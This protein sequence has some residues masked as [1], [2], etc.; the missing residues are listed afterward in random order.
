MCLH[1]FVKLAT[2]ESNNDSESKL[3]VR[4]LKFP[5][6]NQKFLETYEMSKT[7]CHFASVRMF[8]AKRH[9]PTRKCKNTKINCKTSGGVP[10]QI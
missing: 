9:F 3:Q 8:F 2:S 10:S 5:E 4:L 6:E 7:F 1:K